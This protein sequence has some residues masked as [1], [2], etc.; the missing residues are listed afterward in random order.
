LVLN[1]IKCSSCLIIFWGW[2]IGAE[3]RRIAEKKSREVDGRGMRREMA[4]EQSQKIPE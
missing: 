2:R 4:E 1:L 3:Y